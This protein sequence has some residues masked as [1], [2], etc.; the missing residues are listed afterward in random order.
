MA[1]AKLA[2]NLPHGAHLA[3]PAVDQDDIW[4]G[5]KRIR[6]FGVGRFF[7]RAVFL[8]QPRE[9]PLD[10]FSHHAEIVARRNVGRADV[11]LSVLIF[12]EAFRPGD[13]HAADSVRAHD[14]GVII[15]LDPARR[16]RQAEGLGHTLQ[17]T[18]LRRC[19]GKPPPSAS[20][21]LVSA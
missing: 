18:G 13:D 6:H 19:F 20:R 4:P 7:R 16:V 10:D 9:T 15:D 12:D 11:E 5:W 2:K 8:D 14:V 21:A 1:D 17:K 3:L